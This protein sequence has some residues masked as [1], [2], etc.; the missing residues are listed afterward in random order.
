M[1]EEGMCLHE[2]HLVCLLA[3]RKW[4]EIAIAAAKDKRF[5]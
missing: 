1:E 2:L 5:Y 4:P 3:G